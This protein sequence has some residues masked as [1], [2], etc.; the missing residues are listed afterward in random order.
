MIGLIDR[1][2]INKAIRIK[3]VANRTN[4]EKWTNGSSSDHDSWIRSMMEH[5]APV[6]RGKTRHASST[7]NSLNSVFA[8]FAAVGPRPHSSGVNLRGAVSTSMHATCN[9]HRP[10]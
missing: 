2:C 10:R 4:P 8:T 7:D 9:M 6:S 3:S 1:T 5:S